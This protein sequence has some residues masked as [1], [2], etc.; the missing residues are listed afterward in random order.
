MSSSF[1][2]TVGKLFKLNANATQKAGTLT[3]TAKPIS[4]TQGISSGTDGAGRIVKSDA[5]P[6]Q[7]D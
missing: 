4:L 5:V 7:A 1:Y 6:L 3:G 2:D